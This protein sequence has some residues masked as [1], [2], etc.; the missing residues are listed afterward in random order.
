MTAVSKETPL[1]RGTW[2]VTSPE[3]AVRS[4]R[5]GKP[6]GIHC[7]R[8]AARGP[9]GG[10][11]GVCALVPHGWQHAGD[12]GCVVCADGRHDDPGR[13][14]RRAVADH[15][16]HHAVAERRDRHGGR[17]S[18]VY[19]R[20]RVGARGHRAPVPVV[21]LHGRRQDVYRH[22]RRDRGYVHFFGDYAEKRWVSIQVRCHAAGAGGVAGGIRRGQALCPGSG[23]SR[24]DRAG[25]GR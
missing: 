15:G 5:C 6:G 20:R 21:S 1:R 11:E 22:Q 24:L 13:D 3:A 9:D 16:Q 25:D 14:G 12:G 18:R 7:A 17:K 10:R 2:S 4:R 8:H 19:G 23:R